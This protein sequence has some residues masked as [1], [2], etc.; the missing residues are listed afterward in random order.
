MNEVAVNTTRDPGYRSLYRIAGVA[1]LLVAFLTVAEVI[2]FFPAPDS[3]H[4]WFD[5]FQAKPLIGLLDFWGLEVLMYVMFAFVFLALF[6]ELRTVNKSVMAIVLIF[7]LLGTAVFFATNNPFS[8]LSL[9]GRFAEA[10]TDAR[11]SALL[12]AG[13]AILANTNQR[14]IGGFNIGLFLVSIAGLLVSSVMLKAGSFSRFTATI[15]ILAFGLS[16][17]DYLR[18]ALTPSVFI[19]LLVIIPGAL[20]LVIWFVLIGIKLFAL[21]TR[22]H[23]A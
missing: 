14:A 18:Q 12:A 16:L 17:A 15:G 10:T 11:R 1:A 6:V 8:M 5:L 23:G 4:G 21:T 13:E 22:D 7:A 9:S 3:V 20:L 19:A 2:A